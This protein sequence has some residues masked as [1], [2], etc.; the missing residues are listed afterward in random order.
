MSLLTNPF[1]WATL[2]FVCIL[3]VSI[4]FVAIRYSKEKLDTTNVSPKNPGKGEPVTCPLTTDSTQLISCDPK[5]VKSC[6]ACTNGLYAC[7][8]VNKENPYTY[9]EQNSTIVMKVPDGTWCLPT[10]TTSLKCTETTG[11]PILTKISNTENAWTCHC[12]YPE[13]FTTK[14]PYGDCM[15]EV[16][17]NKADGETGRLVCPEKATF[18]IPGQPFDGTW[19]PSVGVCACKDSYTYVDKPNPEDPSR[20]AKFCLQDTCYPGKTD[21]KD[22]TR[23]DCSN[24]STATLTNEG[25]ETYLSYPGDI[26]PPEGTYPTKTCIRDP[27]NKGGVYD[28]SAVGGCRCDKL[29]TKVVDDPFSPTGFSCSDP[30][31]PDKNNPSAESVCGGRGTCTVVTDSEGKSKAECINCKYPYFNDPS[32]R[33]LGQKKASGTSCSNGDECITGVCCYGI[34]SCHSTPLRDDGYCL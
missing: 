30:C 17:C 12:R 8:T 26:T 4:I 15:Y 29:A 13:L 18:C 32:M 19:D 7:Y 31:V 2:V 28:S 9:K 21:P 6:S 10:K 23:C 1:F 22:P 24:I 27:C 20:N 33:C 3:I 16:A 5:D 25:Y 14:G 11:F 34:L